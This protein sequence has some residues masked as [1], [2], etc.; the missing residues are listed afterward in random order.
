MPT[1]GQWHNPMAPAEVNPRISP[2]LLKLIR[3]T[4]PKVV[5]LPILYPCPFLGHYLNL[6]LSQTYFGFCQFEIMQPSDKKYYHF[7]NYVCFLFS[8]TSP[9]ATR[10]AEAKRE[11]AEFIAQKARQVSTQ[12]SPFN[13]V[14]HI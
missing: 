3:I 14:T 12:W 8:G 9:E 6:L 5:P 11:P 4:L 13:D 10:F 2:P 7:Y 1:V